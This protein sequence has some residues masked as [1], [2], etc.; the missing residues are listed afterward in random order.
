MV[1]NWVQRRGSDRDI[2]RRTRQLK[3][4][5][6]LGNELR[7][8]IELPRI[9]TQVVEGIT[10]TLGFRAA[11]LNL[12]HPDTTI[13]VAATSGLN[14]PERQVLVQTPPPLARLLAVMRPEFCVSHSYFISHE[15]KHLLEGM[16]VVTLYTSPASNLPRGAD[17]WHPD[18]V[19]FIP[20]ISPHKDRLLGVISLDQ[21]EDGKIPSLETIE[22]IEM[23]CGQA[24][25]A[26]ETS[27]LFQEREQERKALGGQ[28]FE[29][30]YQLEQVRQGDLSVHIQLSGE[31]LAPMVNS[32]NVV[33][34]ALGGLLSDARRASEMVSASA[35][36][37][38]NAAARMATNAEHQAQQIIAVSGAVGD[39][40]KSVQKIAGVAHNATQVTE[41]GIRIA[42]E[43]REAAE[44]A[45]AGMS[46]V[47]EIALQSVKKMKRLGESSQEIGEIV[48]MVSDFAS[49]TTLL[50]LNAA[51]EAARAGE[52][53]RGFAIVA[54]E[55][56]NLATS[57]A[58]A[59]KH[60]QAR[61]KNI[62]TETNSVVVTIEHSTQQVVQQSELAS[63]AGA[64]LQAVDAVTGRIAE[65]VKGINETATQQAEAAAT[66]SQ[67]MSAIAH[68]TSQTQGSMAQTETAMDRLVEVAHS[69]LRSISAFKLGSNNQLQG[70]MLP[71]PAEE[72]GA[73]IV[74]QPMAAIGHAAEITA[75]PRQT[76]HL[77]AA[78]KTEDSTESSDSEN[79]ENAG[80]IASPVAKGGITNTLVPTEAPMHPATRLD[81]QQQEGAETERTASDPLAAAEAERWQ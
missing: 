7:A 59:T 29:L 57:S 5:V 43:G 8:E 17:A 39:M 19:L 54:Q 55:I 36:E 35:G 38:R 73:D 58:E 24:A 44:R 13:E 4:I 37:S 80:D 70:H 30:M 33:F 6:R 67:S 31:T 50:A 45:A 42:K 65:A 47:R 16:E 68:I 69:L 48:Q 46:A 79:A 26:I 14:E 11:V 32:L 3:E 20:L 9:L 56:R 77:S 1:V 41:E 10:S 12:I 62:Q 23:F 78:E 25:L 76:R 51:I 28:L 18:D 81:D 64:A 49:Q 52:N 60:I 74:T 40:A 75:G 72:L 21:P 71:P 63:Q 34:Q 66:I 2:E 61:I 15:Y 22:M 27:Y 53:G